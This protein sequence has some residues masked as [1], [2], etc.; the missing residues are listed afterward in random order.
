VA[1][2]GHRPGLRTRRR[3]H[4]AW[5]HKYLLNM[6]TGEAR[7]PDTALLPPR[8][9]LAERQAR[10]WMAERLRERGYGTPAG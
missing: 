6:A 3:E 1:I 7:M 9:A 2:C 4:L 5:D 8:S 10:L